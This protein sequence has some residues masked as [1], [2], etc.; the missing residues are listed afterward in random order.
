[1]VEPAPGAMALS[2]PPSM[3]PALSMTALAWIAPIVPLARLM[4][5]EKAADVPEL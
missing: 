3:V 5:E 2:E 1:M 4:I